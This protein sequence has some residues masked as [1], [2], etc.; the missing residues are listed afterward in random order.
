M[1]NDLISRS[2]L[3]KECE[4]RKMIEVFPD[5]KNGMTT[6][7]KRAV[8]KYANRMRRVIESIQAVETAE[9]TEDEV[10]NSEAM[11][12][13]NTCEW[14]TPQDFFEKLDA[15]Y[16]FELDVCATPENAKCKEYIGKGLDG[17]EVRWYG[18][19]W[20]NPPYGRE[21]GKWVRKAYESVR[22][23]HA[24]LVVCLLPAGTDTAWWHEYCMRGE[25]Q[26][27]RGRLK[28]GGAKNSAP[29]P[30]ALV[31]FSR[32]NCVPVKTTNA[33]WLP[34]RVGGYGCTC[35]NCNAQADNDY[36]YC[37]NCGA[38]MGGTEG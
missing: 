33:R 30:S 2:E 12:S 16:H 3:L 14:E 13:S 10:M 29:F 6:S 32:E 17:L 4:R 1:T 34:P 25:I 7:E 31:I 8:L 9:M 19:C 5:W 38:R 35:S 27:I 24:E 11:F 22:K 15:K 36:D 20:M 21:I 37:P 26:F 28:F 23:G 18:R